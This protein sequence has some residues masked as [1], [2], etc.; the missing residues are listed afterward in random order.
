MYRYCS[1]TPRKWN[2]F[3]SGRPPGKSKNGSTGPLGSDFGLRFLEPLVR[4]QV[5]QALETFKKGELADLLQLTLQM[6]DLYA[7]PEPERGT[8]NQ[9]LAS[10]LQ[11]QPEIKRQALIMQ[12]RM[13]AEGYNMSSTQQ[14]LQKLISDPSFESKELDRR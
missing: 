7:L 1:E 12:T 2:R 8:G 5:L 11:K 10:W 3:R 13:I 9:K 6:Q 4:Q 14:A